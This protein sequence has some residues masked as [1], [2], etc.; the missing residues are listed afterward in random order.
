MTAMMTATMKRLILTIVMSAGVAVTAAGCG[1]D[2]GGGTTTG[3]L[4]ATK[5]ACTAYCAAFIA[6][7]CPDPMYTSMADCED[8]DCSAVSD[9]PAKCQGKMQAY[10]DCRKGQA[11]LCGDTGCGAELTAAGLCGGM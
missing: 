3:S 8:S 7:N 2:G 6:K 9:V 1:S 4:E 11:D 5:A 10:Y